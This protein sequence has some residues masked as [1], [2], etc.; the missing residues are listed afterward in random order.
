MNVKFWDLILSRIWSVAE[1]YD[2]W[3]E[4]RVC[5]TLRVAENT[6]SVDNASD[7]RV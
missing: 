7:M 3:T 6:D 4:A 5:V 1:L 2:S